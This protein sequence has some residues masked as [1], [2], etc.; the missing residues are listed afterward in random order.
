MKYLS[1]QEPT[2]LLV[3][4]KEH[5]WEAI[6]SKKTK[7]PRPTLKTLN[8]FPFTLDSEVKYESIL[9]TLSLHQR[10]N[11]TLDSAANRDA[12]REL[13]LN[14]NMCSADF[15]E[16]FASKENA[17]AEYFCTPKT[18]NTWWYDWGS[19]G[20]LRMLYANTPF[21]KILHTLVKVYMD[22]ATVALVI[23]EGK[24]W[25]EKEKLWG[26]LLEKV[27]VTKLLLPEV[28]L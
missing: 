28:P 4:N 3:V 27:T 11:Y 22:Q 2:H 20:A 21:S 14:P 6:P 19:L 7:C 17:D 12:F 5:E 13:G 1:L 24:K 8:R 10:E 15:V 16:L 9:A 18:N 25:E 23:L 26:P